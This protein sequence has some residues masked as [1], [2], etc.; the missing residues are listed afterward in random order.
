[1]KK[2]IAMGATVMWLGVALGAFGAH[3]LKPYLLLHHTLDIWQTAVNYHVWHGISLLILASLYAQ[4]TQRLYLWA[5]WIMLIGL[6]LFSGSL[7][8][9]A[10]SKFAFLTLLTP[11]GGISLLLAWAIVI[12]TALRH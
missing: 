4:H 8:L 10:L 9:I 6:L 1:M 11:L 3:A 2:I 12:W 5:A 7:Y